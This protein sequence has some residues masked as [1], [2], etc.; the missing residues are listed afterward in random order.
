VQVRLLCPGVFCASVAIAGG[1]RT[2]PVR[3]AVDAADAAATMHAWATSEHQVRLRC[4]GAAA[5]RRRG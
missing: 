1:G 3:V 4:G 5:R 2:E